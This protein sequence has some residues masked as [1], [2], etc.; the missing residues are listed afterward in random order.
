MKL[1]KI[2]YILGLG[3]L[4]LTLGG[5]AT[6]NSSQSIWKVGGYTQ[7]HPQTG[8]QSLSAVGTQ[9]YFCKGQV[10]KDSDGDGVL[11]S[12]D[13]CPTTPPN[14]AVNSMGCA[15]DSDGDGVPDYKDQCP[16]T[17]ANIKVDAKGCALDSDGDGVPDYKDQCPTTPANTEVD[18]KGCALDSDGDGVTDAQDACP[19]T[20]ANTPVDARGCALDSDK[21]GVVDYKDDCPETPTG[22]HVTT[23]GCW[24]LENLHFQTGKAT[25]QHRS[26]DSLNKV[27]T[28]LRNA[29]GLKVEVQGHTDSKGS[30][31]LNEKLSQ[32]R[33]VAVLN[34]LAGK[35]VSAANLTAK[36]FGSSN[37]V[38]SNSTSEGR[39]NNRRVELNPMHR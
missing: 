23:K 10:D 26:H 4:S 11:D 12:D 20:P 13:K 37:P 34:Y 38:D 14:T 8:M 39:A 1:S 32:A 24:V 15:L 18:A 16:T 17:P 22:A 2:S 5:C 31:R 25:I 7:H 6:E 27:A 21:D 9:C 19:N 29:P 36:G 28:I 33:A 30:Q 35:G 3:I